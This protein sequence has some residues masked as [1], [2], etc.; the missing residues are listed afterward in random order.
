MK[1]DPHPARITMDHWA[2]LL[3][4][5]SH[6]VSPSTI[7]DIGAFDGRD[8]ARMASRFSIDQPRWYLFEAHP[9]LAKRLP[10]Y[11]PQAHILH[12][13]VSDQDTEFVDFHACDLNVIQNNA[14]SSLRY[15]TDGRQYTH[16]SVPGMSFETWAELVGM[17][18]D[19]IHLVKIDT[20]G[21]SYE[22]LRGFGTWLERVQSVHIECEHRTVWKDQYLYADCE[23][24]LIDAGM[25][26]L[27]L[28][29]C[30]MQSDSVWV[31]KDLYKTEYWK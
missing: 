27:E 1:L 8:T 2:E 28:R 4:Q 19:W 25:V 13:A 17:E 12:L 9:E 10:G 22:V 20:E 31:R 5:R 26:P 3:E 14:L 21:C 23:G 18:K 16:V 15:R 11:Y 6:L 24:L 29:F 30:G 7:F